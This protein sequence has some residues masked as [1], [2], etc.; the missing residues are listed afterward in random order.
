M[1][2]STEGTVQAGTYQAEFIFLRLIFLAEG[3]T[4]KMVVA[5]EGEQDYIRRVKRDYCTD[6]LPSHLWL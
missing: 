3:T 2:R 1:S 6:P 5:Q 4:L